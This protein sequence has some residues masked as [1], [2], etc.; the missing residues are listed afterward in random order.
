MRERNA[1]GRG[2]SALWDSK[3]APSF[4]SAL[5]GAKNEGGRAAPYCRG[6]PSY[7]V[8]NRHLSADARLKLLQAAAAA[9]GG[10]VVSKAYTGCSKP[11]EW[12]CGNGHTWWA[13]P[14]AV[15]KG[16]T[17][18]PRCT[19]YVG[20]ELVRAALIEAL[21]GESFERTRAVKWLSG[22]ELDGY[23]PG[24]R[25]AFEYQGGQHNVRTKLFHRKAGAFEAQVAR[26]ALKAR[27]CETNG[28]T[29]LVVDSAK[30]KHTN[31][32]GFVRGFLR[33]RGLEITPDEGLA[34]P[35][36]FYDTVRAYGSRQ[37]K[38]LAKVRARVEG[39]G[40]RLVSEQYHNNTTPMTFV[41]VAG[42]Q[43]TDVP[44]R[45]LSR[46][47]LC[48]VC[49]PHR[50]GRF[51]RVAPRL[52]GGV[53]D[54]VAGG[55]M[56]GGMGVA[57]EGERP[58]ARDLPTHQVAGAADTLPPPPTRGNHRRGDPTKWA[59]SVGIILANPP[60]RNRAHR[61]TWTC[62]VDA[63]H[64]FVGS[65]SSLCQMKPP[66]LVCPY[67]ELARIAEANDVTICSAWDATCGPTTRITW[68]CNGPTCRTEFTASR[69]GIGRRLR[70]C[71]NPSCDSGAPPRE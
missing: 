67:C 4:F 56:G 61:H 48:R 49:D 26:D 11:H 39:A 69:I 8:R 1:C 40:G 31:V 65:Q 53:L 23:N 19:C 2:A 33:A 5:R 59:S 64:T 55:V 25:L 35:A 32:R 29:L 22:L 71:P 36:A 43:C 18:C 9:R 47:A 16:G 58:E 34:S 62:S 44:M 51:V 30:V 66:K 57:G 63:G 68:L 52:P 37:A 14:T 60:Y 6:M 17:W 10:R 70:L 13:T 50:R 24:R 38:Q 54:G 20:E 28:V 27:L 41:C 7:N 15:K 12:A 3:A 45:I 21:P 42:H 46:V